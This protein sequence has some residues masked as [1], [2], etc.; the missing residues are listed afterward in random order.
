MTHMEV[1]GNSLSLSS[2]NDVNRRDWRMS[3]NLILFCCLPTFAMLM[4]MTDLMTRQTGHLMFQTQILCKGSCQFYNLLQNDIGNEE[5]WVDLMELE[6]FKR[7]Q[8][9]GV[10]S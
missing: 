10:K 2:G 8:Q 5:M 3:K 4:T 7:R 9:L 6:R 1:F